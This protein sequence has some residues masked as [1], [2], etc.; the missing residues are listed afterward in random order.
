MKS[1][2]ASLAAALAILAF[3]AFGFSLCTTGCPLGRCSKG[4]SDPAPAATTP[5]AAPAADVR[6]VPTAAA[7]TSD[8]LPPCCGRGINGTC[9]NPARCPRQG[10]PL[11]ASPK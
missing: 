2:A 6:V 10:K 8:T 7:A 1:I 3:A 11:P 9:A 5:Q 4:T